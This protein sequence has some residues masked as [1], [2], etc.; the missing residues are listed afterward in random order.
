MLAAGAAKGNGE[1]ALAFLDVVGQQ[2]YKKI[3]DAVHELLRLR[4]WRV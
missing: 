3:G 2:V 4:K 1:I